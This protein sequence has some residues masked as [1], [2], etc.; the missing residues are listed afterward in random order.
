[1]PGLGA[2][3]GQGTTIAFGTS[4][5]A[6]RVKSARW[7]GISRQAID[8]SHLGIGDAGANKFGNKLSIPSR[9]TDPGVLEVVCHLDTGQSGITKQPPIDEAAETI[10]LTFPKAPADT[11]AA[12]WE[13]NGYTTD[14]G[15]EIPEEGSIDITLTIKLSGNVTVTA[16]T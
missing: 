4:A 1:M 13:A 8:V 12:K 2:D 10:T 16:A 3:V 15:V 9:Q 7:T 6:A 11:T 5:W 14:A